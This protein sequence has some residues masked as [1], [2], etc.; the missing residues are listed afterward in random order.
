MLVFCLE[1]SVNFVNCNNFFDFDMTDSIESFYTVEPDIESLSYRLRGICKTK[2]R[3]IEIIR[4]AGLIYIDVTSRG[5]YYIHRK[6]L[7]GWHHVDIETF[8]VNVLGLPS[9]RMMFKQFDVEQVKLD[10][11]Q[12]QIDEECLRATIER[13]SKPK[14]KKTAKQKLLE[15][16]TPR[17]NKGWTIKSTNKHWRT[18]E[19]KEELQDA[20]NRYKLPFA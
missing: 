8:G 2:K 11:A 19:G 17:S 20:Y 5:D 18:K 6:Q 9:K 12:L 4:N 7:N 13:M 3:I 16:L 10:F 14:V 15:S 1:V